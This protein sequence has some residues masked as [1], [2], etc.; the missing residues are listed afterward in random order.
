[1][2]KI[3][4]ALLLQTFFADAMEHL[5]S[6]QTAL[7]ELERRPQDEELPHTLFRLAHTLKGDAFLVGLTPVGE[8]AHQLEEVLERLRDGATA[9]SGELV[10]RLL[11]TVDELRALVRA[12]LSVAGAPP[13]RDAATAQPARHTPTLRIDVGKLDRM[14][15]LTGEMTIARGRMARLLGAVEGRVG[16]QLRA[17]QLEADG[18]LLELQEQVMQLR[19]V[20]VGPVFAR[21]GR[22]VRDV[23][24]AQGKEARLVL[25]GEQVE[26]DTSV[27]EHLRDPLTQMVRNAVDH[28][29]ERPEVRRAR[30]K[31]PCGR[32]AL[33][34]FH[35][36]GAVVV[37]LED[38]GQG[39]DA[40]RIG[41]RAIERRLLAPGV[42]LPEAELLRLVFEPGFST[43]ATVTELSGRGVGMDVVRRNVEALR[44]SVA[45]ESRAGRGATVTVRLPLTLAVIEGF[46]V[47]VDGETYVLPVTAV[48]ECF[49]FPRA[50][51]AGASDVVDLRGAPLA[52]ARLRQL[53]G[54][55]G[56]PPPRECVVVVQH[57]GRRAGLVVDR[58]LGTGQAVIK[59]LGAPFERL[60]GISASTILGD[61][62][63]ALIVDVPAVL[64]LATGARPPSPPLLHA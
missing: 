32:I 64:G 49:E 10:T 38:D 57:G 33:R 63:V 41:E 58:L 47:G 11:A 34:A 39:F 22:T 36:G 27:L 31:D 56:A 51:R 12:E 54:L 8:C 28:G 45:I 16:D 35:A 59:P 17:A 30:G 62:R 48:L 44:G 1:V 19:M 4:R 3:D 55:G 21:Y 37:Q 14:L 25:E 24:A 20:P 26:M 53:F 43:A 60:A 46:L 13:V 9:V 23:A 18:V 7:V 61:G 6:L 5:D 42:T 40:A 15:N 52:C 50:P 29:L 2:T